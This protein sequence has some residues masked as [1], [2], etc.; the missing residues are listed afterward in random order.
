VREL[1][2]DLY[3]VQLGGISRHGQLMYTAAFLDTR[4]GTTLID[5]GW[6]DTTE[7]LLTALED[8][9]TVPDRVILTHEGHDHYGGID[10]VMNRYDPELV[11]PAGEETL[12]EAIDHNPDRLLAD[13][14]R[15][16]GMEAVVLPGHSPAPMSLY[17]PDRRTFISADALDGADRQGLPAGFLLP[18]PGLYNEDHDRAAESLQRLLEYDI[19]SVLVFH[20]SHVLGDAGEKIDRL[21]RFKEHYQQPGGV[22]GEHPRK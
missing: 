12:Q 3:D 18:G 10:A 6:P 17:L 20:G 16:A 22:V 19:D 9:D 13:G 8:A 11:V 2:T 21:L 1:V 5:T 14:D 15:I 7:E 4:D